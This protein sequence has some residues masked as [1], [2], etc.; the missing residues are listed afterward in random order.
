MSEE[1][2]KRESALSDAELENVSG[3]GDRD[4]DRKTER[5]A[6]EICVKCGLG[7]GQSRGHCS[8]TPYHSLQAYLKEHGDDSVGGPFSCPYYKW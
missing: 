4:E 2:N 7:K 1:R 6:D 5:R 3:A 8:A